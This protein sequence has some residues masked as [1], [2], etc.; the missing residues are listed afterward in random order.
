MLK[1]ST[2]LINTNKLCM[3]QVKPTKGL[4]KSKK[5]KVNGDGGGMVTD[6]CVEFTTVCYDDFVSGAEFTVRPPVVPPWR[7][8]VSLDFR[9]LPSPD[10]WFNQGSGG[11]VVKLL[12]PWPPPALSVLVGC[13]LIEHQQL[14]A[15]RSGLS[16]SR[17]LKPSPDPGQGIGSLVVNIIQQWASSPQTK[18]KGLIFWAMAG[19]ISFR[20]WPPP[21]L[22]FYDYLLIDGNISPGGH[23]LLDSLNFQNAHSNINGLIDD[24]ILIL[25]ALNK[26]TFASSDVKVWLLF[27]PALMRSIRFVIKCIEKLSRSS[28]H[29]HFWGRFINGFE[30]LIEPKLLQLSF[31]SLV[32]M[33]DESDIFLEIILALTK[34][35][36]KLR[37]WPPPEQCKIEAFNSLAREGQGMNFSWKRISQGKLVL[38]K[39]EKVLRKEYTNKVLWL[40]VANSWDAILLC[41]S[42]LI[43]RCYQHGQTMSYCYKGSSCNLVQS[44]SVW[45]LAISLFPGWAGFLMTTELVRLQSDKMNKGDVLI[46]STTSE[47]IHAFLKMKRSVALMNPNCTYL[48]I[49]WVQLDYKVNLLGQVTI[50][51]YHSQLEAIDAVHKMIFKS[52]CRG[53]QI[54]QEKVHLL[55]CTKIMTHVPWDQGGS[56][57]SA[58]GQG[59]RAAVVGIIE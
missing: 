52:A 54:H 37:P 1:Y 46:N 12:Q 38:W 16:R 29:A 47:Q 18:C 14:N 19:M 22:M 44:I 42:E 23:I 53:N 40:S 8:A 27:S 30:V 55:L 50:A 26:W 5:E 36:V 28:P 45:K 9:F 57:A 43:L 32:S 56:F 41:T 4:T 17:E 59:N 10:I 3:V 2:Q 20:P 39:N 34:E 6:D 33:M 48:L 13:L 7:P 31:L 51:Q 25:L 49:K 58:C 15:K 24:T 11:M 21:D 35:L